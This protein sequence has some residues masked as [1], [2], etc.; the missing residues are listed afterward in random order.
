MGFGFSPGMG[1]RG[2]IQQMGQEAKGGRLFNR[3]AVVQ[4]LRFVRPYRRRMAAAFLFMLLATICTLLAPYLIK[5]AID[6][7]IAV[8]DVDGL[9]QLALYIGLAYL[10]LYA[11]TAGQEFLL[12]W[13]SQRVLADV[14]GELLR[15]LQTLSLGY[16]DRT[17]SGV[18]V[19]RVIN[20][21]AVINDLLTQGV[22]ALLGDLLVLAGIIVIML[23]MSPQLALYTFAVLPLMIAVTYIFSRY[24]RDAFRQTR[25]RIAALVGS[26][27]E[28]IGGIRVIQAFAQEEAIAGRF[29]QVNE[30][31]REANVNAIR[32][33]FIF[34]PSIEFLGML[35][36]AVVL[37]FG[38][39]AVIGETVTLGV[40]VAFLAYV[41]RFFQ[42]IQELSRLYTTLQS[43]M[44]GGEQVMR[45]LETVPDVRDAP[46]AVEMPP[47]KGAVALEKVSFSY[48]ANGPE[49][50]HAVDLRI[51]PGQMVALVGPTGAGKTTIANLIPRF[52]EVSDGR[53]TIDGR[54]TRSVSQ[55]SLRAQFG[56]VPQ[57]PFLFAGSVADN[58]RF[59]RLDA[60]QAEVEAAARL[61][62]AHEFIARLPQRYETEILEGAVNLSVG[63]RQL[64]CIARAAL[65]NPRIL[66]LDE[67]TASV[68]TVTEVLIQQALEQLMQGRTAIVIAHR[69][70]TIRYADMI[71]LV[72]DG[73]IVARGPHEELIATS[74]LYRELYQRQFVKGER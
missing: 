15:H 44:A 39:R 49:I 36:T 67:A 60:S 1:P 58:I 34:L 12:G 30:A 46:D 7:H 50:L 14:R 66:I 37:Y 71:C 3:R 53:V 74:S 45:L 63:Q 72:R 43:A 32:L 4:M 6:A 62:N 61:A 64:L 68:D 11:A 48:Q 28:T 22:I 23:T 2:A 38:G 70:S 26:L 55:A 42:P 27:A 57:D 35:A 25:Q 17:I 29:E 5:V 59:G 24:A 18:T 21:V 8:G 20:D 13:T 41:T 33:S 69:L 47:I 52:Y 65:V 9:S 51:E 73:R 31:N 10:G 16:H 56:L 19:S 40:M 54:D